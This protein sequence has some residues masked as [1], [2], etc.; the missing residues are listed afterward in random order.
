LQVWRR[1]WG[2]SDWLVSWWSWEFANWQKPTTRILWV[3]FSL[4]SKIVLSCCVQLNGLL[5]VL[6]C[7][8]LRKFH[9][10]RSQR[11]SALDEIIFNYV[12][13]CEELT[14]WS[15]SYHPKLKTT[16]N[17]KTYRQ[18]ISIHVVRLWT[19][20]TFVSRFCDNCQT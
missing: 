17:S 7:N 4:S 2:S 9:D 14:N 10:K 12:I 15:T 13:V 1:G 16:P 18:K 3:S 5:K 6:R 19:H 20:Q 8:C 11:L